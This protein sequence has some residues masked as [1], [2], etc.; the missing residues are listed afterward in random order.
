MRKFRFAFT[1]LAMAVFSLAVSSVANAQ[2]CRTWV[3]GVGDDANPCSRT[4]PCK[5]FAGAISKTAECGEID[6][7]DP[8]GFGAVTITKCM[9]IDGTYGAGFGSILVAG[10][11]GVIVNVTTNPATAKVTLRKLSINGGCLPTSSVHGINYLAGNSLHVQQ[12]DI[13]NFGSNGINIALG[14]SG[15]A[16]IQDTTIRECAGSAISATATAGNNVAVLVTNAE[17]DK[18]PNGLSAAANSVVT[19]RNS[20]F[21]LCSSNGIN[22]ANTA[23]V[24]VTDSM[25]ANDGTGINI[26]AGATGRLNNNIFINNGTGVANAGTGVSPA[27]NNKFMGNLT[28]RSGA[29][30]VTTGSSVQ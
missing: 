18:V 11:S 25:F 16:T 26:V 14:T 22:T 9:T 1:I 24:N 15:N 19:V 10:T 7:L 23:Q 30:F 5:T 8:G 2:A 6:V 17:I 13:F 27:A 29:A 12:C 3:S 4:A 21:A 20:T 28:D